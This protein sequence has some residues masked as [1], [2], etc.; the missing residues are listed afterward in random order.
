[1]LYYLKCVKVLSPPQRKN[2]SMYSLI[3]LLQA[4]TIFKYSTWLP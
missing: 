4:W 1:M 3:F 2:K